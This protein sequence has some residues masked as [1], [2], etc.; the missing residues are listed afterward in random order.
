MQFRFYLSEAVNSLL[1]NWV[2]SV[3]AV[4]TVL[5]SMFVLGLG[6]IL[7]FNFQ[8]AISD[9][10]SKLE[11]EVF[12]KNTATQEEIDALGE[13][14]R[15]MPEVKSVYFVSK[16]E[17]LETLRES[18]E[19]NEDILDALSGNPLP[20]SYQITLEDPEQI[21]EVASRF[22]DNP[23]VDNTPGKDPPDG[24]KYGGETSDRVLRVTTIFMIGGSGF[25]VL[26][27]IA[28]ILLIS[29]TIRLSIFA[30]RREV[31]I[32]RL[33][34]ATNWFIRWP[35]VME[36]VISG[37]VGATAAALLVLVANHFLIESVVEKMPFLFNATAVPTFTLTIAI[38][39][40]GAL[41]GAIGSTLA[42]RRFL[43]I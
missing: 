12:I 8:D 41:L 39:G 37:V 2:M 20:P 29:N 16:E 14:I 30:R 26:L 3:A 6:L 38:I 42:L 1:R 13:E 23:V 10:R 5:V 40:G 11:I 24:V 32:M 7:F 18:L 36:G 35:F 15:A 21:E 31:E 17:A 33:V 25:V 43:K 34:G 19:G 28:S 4:V 9:L 27:T 22:F